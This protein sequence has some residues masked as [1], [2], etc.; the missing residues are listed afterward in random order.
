LV[1]LEKCN[2]QD[3]VGAG[4]GCHYVGLWYWKE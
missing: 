1:L 4:L 2:G 3:A